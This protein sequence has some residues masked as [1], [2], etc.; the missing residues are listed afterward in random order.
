MRRSMVALALGSLLAAFGSAEG[1]TA[2]RVEYR[3][4]RLGVAVAVGDLPLRV[5]ARSA[6]EMG[7]TEVVWRPERVMASG[8]RPSWSHENLNRG[9]LNHILGKETVKRIA[10][11]GRDMGARG[12]LRGQWYQVDR[13]SAV[14]E[15]TM[16]GFPVAEAWDYGGDGHVD[17]VYF[18]REPRRDRRW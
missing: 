8:G 16:S 11:H 7:W 4:G 6:R 17:R 14:L 12:A 10:R 2:A 13:R 15:V 5:H 9:E 3:D 1:Q 18:A